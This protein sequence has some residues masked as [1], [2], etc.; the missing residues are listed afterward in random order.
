MYA[1]IPTLTLLLAASFAFTAD[2]ATL[3]KQ[4][5]EFVRKASLA[6]KAEVAISDAAIQRGLLSAEERRF[7]QQMVDDHGKMNKEL[8]ALVETKNLSA[9]KDLD[10]EAL[11]K[12][13]KLNETSDKSFAETYLECQ[14]RDHKAA[15]ELFEEEA[16]DGKDVDLKNFVNRHLPHLQAHLETAKALEAKH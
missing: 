5:A 12:L 10:K 15:M 7:A 6:G 3:S 14:V 8:A 4:D 2:T 13:G 11:E 16:K 1:L 9:A